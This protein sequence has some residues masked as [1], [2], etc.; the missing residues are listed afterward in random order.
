ML[1]ATAVRELKEE[2]PKDHSEPCCRRASKQQAILGTAPRLWWTCLSAHQQ[3][4]VKP[5]RRVIFTAG[6]RRVQ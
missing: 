4:S 3:Q 1:T 6:F 5:H 2:A